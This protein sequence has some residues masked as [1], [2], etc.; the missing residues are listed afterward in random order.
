M[1]QVDRRQGKRQPTTRYYRFV[2]VLG[3]ACDDA[4]GALR[5]V[6][7]LLDHPDRLSRLRN[8]PQLFPSAIGGRRQPGP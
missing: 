3:E 2:Q 8:A 7:S 1:R 6:L 5:V 4:L